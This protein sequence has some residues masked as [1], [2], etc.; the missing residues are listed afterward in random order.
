MCIFTPAVKQVDNTSIFCRRDGDQQYIVY[1]TRYTTHGILP[2]AMILPIPIVKGGSVE[3]IDLS[4]YPEFMGDVEGGFFGGGQPRSF[5]IT[6]GKTRSTLPVHKVGSFVA[7]VVPTYA[8]MDRL[9]LRFRVDEQ[10]LSHFGNIKENYGFV[11]FQLSSGTAKTHPMAFSF[12]TAY[13]EDE[14]TVFYPTSHIHDGEVHNEEGFDH[15]LYFQTPYQHHPLGL[16]YV[17]DSPTH[18]NWTPADVL[19]GA[20]MDISRCKNMVDPRSPIWKASVQ[21]LRRN[22]DLLGLCYTYGGV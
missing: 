7:S 6:R 15:T 2:V 19:P 1:S 17:D 13:N 5:S 10:S 22:G 14:S 11:V 20:H 4:Q 12:D 8:D 18:I 9:D 3:F 16:K 21:G